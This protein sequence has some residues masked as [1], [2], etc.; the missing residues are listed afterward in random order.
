MNGHRSTLRVGFFRSR[1]SKLT[2]AYRCASTAQCM[3]SPTKP[4]RF[5]T[6]SLFPGL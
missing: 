5:R 1:E 4:R 3:Q 6:S 2:H